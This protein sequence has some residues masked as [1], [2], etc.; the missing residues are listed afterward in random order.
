MRTSLIALLLIA[1]LATT[2]CKKKAPEPTAAAPAPTATAPAF[3]WG[4]VQYAGAHGPGDIGKLTYNV[5]VKNGTDKGL[6][7]SE[8][9]LGVST[10][11]GRLCV[12]HGDTLEKFNPTD[13]RDLAWTTDCEF[14]KLPDADSLNVKGTITYTLSGE[15]TVLQLDTKLEYKQN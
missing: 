5:N 7:V 3:T 13:G 12:A 4:V 11:A 6:I 10:D 14:A 8:W 9:E 1:P 2:G 15:Q